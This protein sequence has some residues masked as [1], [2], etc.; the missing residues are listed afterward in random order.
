M[1]QDWYC[2]QTGLSKMSISNIV[3]ELIRDGFVRE[4]KESPSKLKTVNRKD[5]VV[6]VPDCETYAVIGLYI[7]RAMLYQFFPTEM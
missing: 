3:A 7:S 5:P 6:L 1:S 2:G 4:Q